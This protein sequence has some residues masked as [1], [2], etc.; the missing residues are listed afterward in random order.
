MK[1]KPNCLYKMDNA[2]KQLSMICKYYSCSEHCPLY[3]WEDNYC[4]Y[5]LLDKQLRRY[6]NK[7]EEESNQNTKGVI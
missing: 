1:R 2:H 6:K 3:N 5:E 7:I 4:A